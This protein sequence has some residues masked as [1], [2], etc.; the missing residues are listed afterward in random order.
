MKKKFFSARKIIPPCGQ[1]DS[2]QRGIRASISGIWKV[3][4]L[5][6]HVSLCSWSSRIL[7]LNAVTICNFPKAQLHCPLPKDTPSPRK[8]RLLSLEKKK[9]NTGIFRKG[10]PPFVPGC[11]PPV[12]PPNSKQFGLAIPYNLDQARR[13]PWSSPWLHKNDLVWV[14]SRCVCLM[15]QLWNN[16]SKEKG[17]FLKKYNFTTR[18][19]FWWWRWKLYQKSHYFLPLKSFFKGKII[20]LWEL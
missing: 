5:A 12:R 18:N 11:Q 7:V 9:K 14:H 16:L 8:W 15:L 17:F 3:L 20:P 1:T 10:A 4:S 13:N 19:N 6:D 2:S